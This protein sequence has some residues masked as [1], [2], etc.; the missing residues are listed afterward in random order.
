MKRF[1][2]ASLILMAAA[3]ASAQNTT[4]SILIEKTDGSTEKFPVSQVSQVSFSEKTDYIDT[5]YLLNATYST[6]GDKGLYHFEAGNGTPDFA[7]DPTNIGDIQVAITLSGAISEDKYA[8]VLPSGTYTVGGPSNSIDISTS[9]LWI[10]VEDGPDGVEP[11]MIIGGTAYVEEDNGDYVVEMELNT[12][13]GNMV[14]LRYEGGLEFIPSASTA[15][16]IPEDI[17]DA[18]FSGAQGRF[19]GNWWYPFSYDML[20][21][22]YTGEF[23]EAGIQENGYWLNIPLNLPKTFDSENRNVRIPDGVYS[24]EW[25]D[26]IR[27]CSLMPYTFD[28]GKTI[29]FWG[30]EQ[31]AGTY[32]YDIRKDGRRYL[33]FITSG[34]ITVSNNGTDFRF[35]FVTDNDKHITGTYSGTPYIEYKCDNAN[36]PETPFSTLK[37]DTDIKF[38]D[39]T[40]C[41]Y[42]QEGHSYVQDLNSSILLLCAPEAD[43]GHFLQLFMLSDET[44]FKDG[45]YSVAATFAD[46]TILPGTL[47]YGGQTLYSWYGNLDSTDPTTGVQDELAPIAGGTITVTTLENGHRKIEINLTDDAGNSI[48]STW[49]GEVNMATAPEEKPLKAAAVKA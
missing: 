17:S 44:D 1:L 36:A 3:A 12:I 42:Y 14:A 13:D 39:D 15:D 5:Y 45:T 10:R 38:A 25:R 33:G 24:C 47:D 7:G 35:D 26:V 43:H 48:T 21:Q 32:L 4:R 23:N 22:L 9:G 18:V 8:A 29:D 49:E 16:S 34:T 30:T 27:D 31:P 37:G 28:K 6:R 19:Y 20:L 2:S 40:V 11:L 41:I 46:K